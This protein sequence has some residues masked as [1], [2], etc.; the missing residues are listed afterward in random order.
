MSNSITMRD[1]IKISAIQEYS[2]A[3][4]SGGIV[5]KPIVM[6]NGRVSVNM[7]GKVMVAQAEWLDNVIQV[8]E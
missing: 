1:S 2:H 7:I 3:G 5:A 4:W 6:A 8:P